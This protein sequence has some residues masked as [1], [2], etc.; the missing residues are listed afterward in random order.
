LKQD[1]RPPLTRFAF[2]AVLTPNARRNGCL[3]LES[4]ERA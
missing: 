4:Y 3:V 2:T 1:W